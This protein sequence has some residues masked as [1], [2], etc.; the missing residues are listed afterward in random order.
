M[1][2]HYVTVPMPHHASHSGYGRL[3]DFIRHTPLP[4]SDKIKRLPQEEMQ[5]AFAEAKSFVS[6]YSKGD[7]ESEAN[8]NVLRP[9]INKHVCHLLYGENSLYHTQKSA[10]NLKRIFVTFHQP[11]QY[12]SQFVRLREPLKNVDGII[13]VGTNQVPF[14]C[15]FVDPS[16]VFFVPHGVD[17]DF[18]APPVDE[19]IRE[20]KKCLFVGD[21]LRDFET[22]VEAARLLQKA[23]PEIVIDVITLEKNR[24]H[25]DG[26]YNVQFHCGIA[27][28]ELLTKYQSSTVLMLP[29]KDCTANNTVLEA[30]ACGL[31]VITTDIGGI[32]DYVDDS[33]A[34]LCKPD[35]ANGVA[36]TALDL[37]SDRQRRDEMGRLGRRRA[38]KYDWRIIASSLTAI[39]MQSFTVKASVGATGNSTVFSSYAHLSPREDIRYEAEVKLERGF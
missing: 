26:L 17:I 32:R 15:E 29:L 12:H 19:S 11:P 6:W 28:I 25:F 1:R 27:E 18:F 7:L 35:D 10:S 23:D 4:F 34:G 37:L 5:Q 24:F 20:K 39:Y 22:L 2:V 16:K 21:W 30:M 31:P 8:I 9:L 13:V 33:C 3:L 36:Q 38:E 14:F